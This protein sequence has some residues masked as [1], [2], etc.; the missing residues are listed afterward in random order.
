MEKVFALSTTIGDHITPFSPA[1]TF[2]NIASLVG[3]I[4]SNAFFIAGVI[5]FIFMIVGG[6]GI[7]MSSGDPKKIEQGKNTLTMA[8]IGFLVIVFSFWIVQL[9]ELLIGANPLQLYQ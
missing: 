5:A 6:F 7:I 1:Q 2:P 4:T 9:I 8:I 3:V